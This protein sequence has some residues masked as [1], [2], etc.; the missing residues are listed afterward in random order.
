MVHM[1]MFLGV[2]LVAALLCVIQPAAGD[3]VPIILRGKVVMDDGTPPPVQ[4]AVE[5]QCSDIQ[6]SAPGPLINK[7]GEY[8]WR[9]DIDFTASRECW[10]FAT[11]KGWTSTRLEVQGLDTTRAV[12]DLPALIVREVVADAYQISAPEGGPPGKAKSAWNAAMKALDAHNF[13]EAGRKFE[14]A[15][16][17]V[18][19]FAEGWHALGLVDEKLNKLAEAKDAYQHAIDANPKLLTPYVTLTRLMIKTKDWEGASK[20]ADALIKADPKHTFTEAYLHLAVA[21]YQLKDL[22]G[23]EM[24]VSEEIR[25]DPKH[26]NPR[27]EY[28]LGRILEAKGDS[29]GAIAHI[30][31]Y[32]ELDPNT[33]D[34]EQVKA[35]LAA[36]NKPGLTQIEPDLEVF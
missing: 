7:K 4:F 36:L 34:V 10:I 17:A 18:P 2:S 23:A 3:V 12:Q 35:H 24:N 26:K 19:K 32:L 9:M 6:G 13:P 15:V 22:A 30:S 21:R 33:A 28:V 27:A 16:A 8:V 31:K 14:E 20:E 25:L 5:R 29:A 1:R 11:H